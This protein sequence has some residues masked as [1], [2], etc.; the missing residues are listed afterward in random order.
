M[1]Y[2]GRVE[3]GVIVLEPGVTMP[4]GIRVRVEP[5]PV[6]ARPTL[7]SRLIEWAGGGVDLPADMARRHDEYL[8]PRD[9]T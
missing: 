5:V 8:H 9:Q 1:P 4:E 3:N 2:F 6:E 7:A